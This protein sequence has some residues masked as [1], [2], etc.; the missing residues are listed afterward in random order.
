MFFIVCVYVCSCEG[1]IIVCC[2]TCALVARACVCL[3]SVRIV[4]LR[5]NMNV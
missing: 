1:C 2:C 5:V 3:S 4:S